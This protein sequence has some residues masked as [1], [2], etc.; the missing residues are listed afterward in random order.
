MPE[1]IVIGLTGNIATGKSIVLRM[2]QELG[3][4]VIDADKLVHRLMVQG[5]PAHQAIVEEFGNFILDDTGQI[6]RRRLGKIAF[7][8]PEALTRLEEITHPA[9]RQEIQQRIE[10]SN[11]S[12]VAVEAIKLFESGL[13]DE[14]QAT[15]VVTS[16]SE[17]QL[18]RLVERRKM[19]PD[20]AQQRIKAQSSAQEKV[21]K[22]D[23]VIDNSGDLG[24]TWIFVKKHYAALIQDRTDVAEAV[25]A[26]P[27]P[28]PVAQSPRA[29]ALPA[30][31][32]A[33]QV[34]IRRAKR[35][36]LEAMAKL[37]AAG[38]RGAIRPNM[39]QMM[40]ALFSRAYLVATYNGHVVGT[41]GWLTENLI[42]GLQDFYVLHDDLWPSVGRRM[43]DRIHEE[44]AS[45]S[46]E[47][48]LAFVLNQAGSRPVEFFES[49]EYQQAEGKDLGYM[50]KDA[51]LEWQ[52]EGSVLLYKK[53]REQRIMVPM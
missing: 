40:E 6:D 9:V 38:T 45:L 30:K 39:N 5:G 41:A 50:W 27:A 23:L 13:A 44:V 7:T 48:A 10:N 37:I 34:E 2:L 46:C 31:V 21:A 53:L 28:T 52:P 8:I 49:Q 15:W 17:I 19:S 47:V 16:P 26:E 1:K 35:P 36:D 51:A 20:Q 18:K 3:A 43:L 25:P 29:A 33:E 32:E 22:A 11:A 12:V 14:C 4:T 42:A 24:K